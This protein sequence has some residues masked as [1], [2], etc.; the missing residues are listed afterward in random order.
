MR[1]L[2][3]FLP[4]SVAA[5]AGMLQACGFAYDESIDGPYRLVA[6]D[7]EKDMGICRSDDNDNSGDCEYIS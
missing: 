7:I 1:R 3:L 5:I 4:F 6:V 2:N